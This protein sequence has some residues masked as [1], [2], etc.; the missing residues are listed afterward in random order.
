M[1]VPTVREF[2]FT[3]CVC[4]AVA[5]FIRASSELCA[6]SVIHVMCSVYYVSFVRGESG[7]EWSQVTGQAGD[8]VCVVCYTI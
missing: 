8:L 2:V 7:A 1:C 4:F 6:R 3:F 5:V